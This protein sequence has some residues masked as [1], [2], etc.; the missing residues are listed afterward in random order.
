[1]K[2]KKEIIIFWN[3]FSPVNVVQKQR[4]QTKHQQYRP[5]NSNEEIPVVI[6]FVANK[7]RNIDAKE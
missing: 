2:Y 6:V 5:P 4:N 7:R 3:I 1:M